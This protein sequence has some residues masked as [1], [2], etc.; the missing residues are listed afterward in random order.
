MEVFGSKGKS[1]EVWGPAASVEVRAPA[2]GSVIGDSWLLE[3]VTISAKEIVDVRQCFED[4]AYIYALGNDQGKCVI[5]LHF[6]VFIG[7]KDCGQGKGFEAVEA[8]MRAYAQNRISTE[9]GRKRQIIG[10]GSFARQGW[11]VGIDISGLDPERSVCH[12]AATFIMEL[13]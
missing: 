3:G 13:V 9:E 5:V 2:L 1:V 8:G 12:A 6:I 4:V 10:I 11:L 7:Q